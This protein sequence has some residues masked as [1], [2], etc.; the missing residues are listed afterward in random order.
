MTTPSQPSANASMTRNS[1]SVSPARVLSALLLAGLS[2]TAVRAQAQS[3]ERIAPKEPPAKAPVD[4][5]P[6]PPMPPA[7][8]PESDRVIL[9]QLKGLVFVPTPA[10]IEPRGRAITGVD[11]GHI[12]ILD[13]PGFRP[14]A[15]AYIGKPLRLADLNELARQIVTF[16]RDNDHPLVDVLVPEQDIDNG[17][18]QVVVREFTVGQVAAEGNEWFDSALLTRRIS[19]GP[20]DRVEG[21]RLL[22]EVNGLNENPFRQV[23]LVYRPGTAPGTTDLVLSTR[24]RFPLRVYAGYDNSGAPST[25]RDRWNLGFNWGNAFW[26]D[27]QLSYQLTTSNDFWHDRPGGRNASFV[28]HSLSWLA[29][30]PWQDRLMI[31]GSYEESVPNVGNDFGLVGKSGQASLRYQIPLKRTEQFAHQ[32][33]FGYDFKTTNNNL[34]F[35]GVQISRTATEIN[36]FS[37][38]YNAT[39]GDSWGS[40]GWSNTL[41]WSPGGLTGDNTNAAFQPGDNQSGRLGAKANYLYVRSELNRLVKLPEDAVWATRVVGQLSNRALLDTEQL[42]AGGADILRGYDER[43]VNGD[44]GVLIST[45]L[46]SRAF[47]LIQ[48]GPDDALQLLAFFDYG[49]LWNRNTPAGESD[50]VNLASTGVGLGYTYGTYLTVKFAYGWQLRKLPGAAEKGELSHVSVTLSY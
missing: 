41:V 44:Q 37:A 28:G 43:A 39:L 27:E 46:R 25:G 50:N 24:D 34:A 26:Q 14:I 32:L 1:M 15:E 42:G 12:D 29:P 45:E 38:N 4:Q 48:R 21:E 31:F 20:G 6:Q 33:E 8:A 40:T 13:R 35:G 9:P 11:T 23:D 10:A 47:K 19:A 22:R 17:T 49:S 16:Y 30:L 2:L 5:A 36:Q 7:P 3:Y 18:V